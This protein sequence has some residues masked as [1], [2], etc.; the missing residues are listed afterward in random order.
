MPTTLEYCAGDLVVL[1]KEGVSAI[2]DSILGSMDM[3][4]EEGEEARKAAVA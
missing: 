1:I 2:T 4:V 3:P